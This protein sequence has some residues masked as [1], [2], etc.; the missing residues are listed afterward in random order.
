MRQT[1]ESAFDDSD[2]APAP[3]HMVPAAVSNHLL[4]RALSTGSPSASATLQRVFKFKGKQVPVETKVP[5]I[6]GVS[7]TDL[8][9][10]ADDEHD[11]GAIEGCR[12]ARAMRRTI[13][14]ASPP[15]TTTR[16]TSWR[17]RF[18]ATRRF[19]W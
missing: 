3:A 5:R 2:V 1:M 17:K 15:S 13:R 10:L 14:P 12:S 6:H 9:K 7:P 4:A 19:A 8:Q 18:L 16:I 11:Y